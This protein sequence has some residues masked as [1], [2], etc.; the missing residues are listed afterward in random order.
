MTNTFFSHHSERRSFLKNV[1]HVLKRL[2]DVETNGYSPPKL[3]TASSI[4]EDEAEAMDAAQE[5]RETASSR[6]RKKKKKQAQKAAD[7][8]KLNVAKAAAAAQAPSI[9]EKKEEKDPLVV[10]LLGMG[11]AEEQINVA[12][13]AC[14]GTNRATADDLVTW[15]L[16]QDA[17]GNIRGSESDQASTTSEPLRQE[18]VEVTSETVAISAIEPE[19]VK[20]AES[21]AKEQAE[22][23]QRLAAKREEQRR[24]NR[25]WNDREQSRQQEAAKTKIKRAMAPPLPTTLP[26]L[27]SYTAA[28]P[29]LQSS[30]PNEVNTGVAP[31]VNTAAKIGPSA[32]KTMRPSQQK[33]PPVQSAAAPAT[34]MKPTIQPKPSKSNPELQAPPKLATGSQI[35][36]VPKAVYQSNAAAANPR[37]EAKRPPSSTGSYGL[38]PMGDDETTVSYFG[39][40]RGL[41]VSSN[42]FAPSMVPTLSVNTSAPIPPPGFMTSTGA[43]P[44]NPPQ[45]QPQM[46]LPLLDPSIANSGDPTGFSGEQLQLGVI[47]A[48]AKAFVPSSYNPSMPDSGSMPSFS[49]AFANPKP[50][51]QSQ[52]GSTALE[53]NP[54]MGSCEMP[55]ALP[56]GMGGPTGMTAGR[57]ESSLPN[58]KDRMPS[59]M[60]INTDSITLTNSTL[61]MAGTEEPS[62]AGIPLGFVMDMRQHSGTSSLLSSI[63]NK[64]PVAASSIWGGPQGVAPLGRLPSY[65]LGENNGRDGESQNT[66]IAGWGA[67]TSTN[68]PTGGQGSIW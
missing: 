66:S 17:D 67:G 26:P 16:G 4:S 51:S 56:A 48:T 42:S 52:L 65:A 1:E 63:S 11:F 60:P 57:M 33:A 8:A 49:G 10:A 5:Q 23:T 3:D 61:P 40:H 12:V 50:S 31:G 30:L 9:P 35:P 46:N 53:D 54:M 34:H 7:G 6:K 19:E 24:L 55:S 62:L 45:M 44:V 43:P 20:K 38:P 18:V 47:R 37:S 64:P 58:S 14:G 39:S 21:D 28:Y 32:S 27:D 25:A 22:A 41:S 36:S 13:K 59:M 2:T 29:S 15:I 68:L